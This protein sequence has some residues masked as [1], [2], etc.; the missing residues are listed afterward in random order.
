MSRA[1]FRRRVSE[2]IS[3]G[4]LFGLM[5]N[6]AWCHFLAMVTQILVKCTPFENF[7]PFPSTVL[8]FDFL[9]D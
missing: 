8:E 7:I 2:I 4:K 1:R 5:E 6:G 3:G 9:L